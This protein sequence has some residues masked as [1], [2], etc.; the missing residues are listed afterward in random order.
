MQ[1]VLISDHYLCFFFD[2][3]GLELCLI[4][5]CPFV[6]LVQLKDGEMVVVWSLSIFLVKGS[7]VFGAVIF[8]F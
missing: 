2:G 3:V 8:L 5:R 6:R 4:V 7:S 1:V